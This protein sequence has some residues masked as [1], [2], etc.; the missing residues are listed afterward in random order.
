MASYSDRATRFAEE[1]ASGKKKACSYVKMAC[2]RHLSDLEKLKNKGYPYS[3]PH[4]PE[5]NKGDD[6]CSFA[7]KMVHVSGVW[8]GKKIKL[9]DWQCFILCLLFGWVRR[10]DGMRRFRELFALIPRKNSK[11]TLGA[12]IGLYML[13]ADNEQ[14][15]QVFS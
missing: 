11:S 7:E 4:R 12:I 10:A 13:C 2:Q 6:I 1:I 8:T 9:E 5:K 15:A 14:G 3:Y